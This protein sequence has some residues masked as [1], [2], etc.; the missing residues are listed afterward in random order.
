[1]TTAERA[2]QS[3]SVES[4]AETVDIDPLDKPRIHDQPALQHSNKTC[5]ELDDSV[6]QLD[7]RAL[8]LSTDVKSL[9]CCISSEMSLDTG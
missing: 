1:M 4:L 8:S 5:M 2:N 6:P 9:E 3:S 7:L